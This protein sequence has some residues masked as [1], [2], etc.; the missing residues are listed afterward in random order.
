[1]SNGLNRSVEPPAHSRNYIYFRCEQRY[2]REQNTNVS[3]KDDDAGKNVTLIRD[4]GLMVLQ[5]VPRQ[6]NMES[7]GR[8]E[9]QME[10]DCIRLPVPNEIAGGEDQHDKERIERKE[11][12]RKRD[13]KIV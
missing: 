3:E 6:G 13:N 2:A 11:I 12:R 5:N 1:M 9:Q 10:P 4:V 8:A 7:I